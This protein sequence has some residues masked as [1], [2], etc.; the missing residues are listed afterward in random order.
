MTDNYLIDDEVLLDDL[1]RLADQLGHP[2]AI[3]DVKKYGEHSFMTY[4][5]HFST[6]ETA[7][8]KA[9]LIPHNWH[10]LTPRQIHQFNRAA[11]DQDPREAMT[12]LFYQFLP[13]PH[14]VYTEF[15]E[16]WLTTIADKTVIRLP[17]QYGPDST[18]W[19]LKIPTTWRNPYTGQEESTQLPKLLDWY[20]TTHNTTPLN[21]KV[22]VIDFF[23]SL[24][25]KIE[26]SEMRS[27]NNE[28][29]HKMIS[30]VQSSDLHHT[31]G[32]HLARNGAPRE[33][34]ARRMGFDRTDKAE[35]YF[36]FP[37][38]HDQF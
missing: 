25:D 5:D 16:E 11:L 23:H 21:S 13:V 34:I 31:H 29:G 22:S 9:G 7:V 33:W 19:E 28:V 4:Y 6:Y 17:D 3:C 30:R 8:V 2:P 10:P 26:F 36:E 1:R 18:I 37:K 38:H 12:A 20:L 14:R 32:I 15:E 24:F 27:I 35:V